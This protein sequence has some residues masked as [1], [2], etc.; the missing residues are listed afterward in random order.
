MSRRRGANVI[1]ETEGKVVLQLRDDLHLWGIFGG[2]VEDGEDPEET[3]LREI[4][5]ELTISLDPDRLVLLKV[6]DGPRYESHLFHYTVGDELD[7]AALTEGIRFE[8]KSRDDLSPDEV[9]P[10]HWVMLDWFWEHGHS[11]S[12]T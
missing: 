5:E 6:F 3:A 2:L 4:G 1:L 7:G 9:V 10:W 8:A 12:S 11:S